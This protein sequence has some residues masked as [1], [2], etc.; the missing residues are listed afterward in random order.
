MRPQQGSSSMK[1]A[2]FDGSNR[3]D[4]HFIEVIPLSACS[5]PVASLRRASSQ[6]WDRLSCISKTQEEPS[7]F[8]NSP[9]K[10]AAN[11]VRS[12]NHCHNRM[13]KRKRRT[14]RFNSVS[15]IDRASRVVFPLL[16][17]AINL[18][19]WYSY[20]ARTKRIHNLTV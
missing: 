19:Y 20:L 14:P 1:S 6:P 3:G 17:L 16:F 11:V 4:P 12:P 5:I 15:K 13:R 8:L 18:F 7:I 2:T 10:S 9:A